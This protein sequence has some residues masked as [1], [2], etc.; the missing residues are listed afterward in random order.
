M[1]LKELAASQHFTEPPPRYSEAS[2]IKTLE[3]YGIGRPSTYASI[4]STLQYRKY[5]TLEKRRFYPTPTGRIVSKFLTKHFSDY[6]DY[7]FTAKLENVLDEISR[8][9]KTWIPA[10]KE[11][12]QPFKRLVDEKRD[13]VTKAEASSERVLG[14]DPE[15]GKPVSARYGRYGPYIQIGTKDDEEKPR[16]A[17]LRS[18]QKMETISFEEAME[19]FKLPRDLGQTLDGEPVS[20]GIG[21]YGPFIK[22]GKKYVSLKEDDPHEIDLERALIVIAEKKQTD[23]G[24]VIADF[25]KHK[26][27]VLNGRY[28]PYVTD[29]SKNVKIPKEQEPSTLTAEQCLELIAK[30]PEKRKRAPAKKKSKSK[31]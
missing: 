18:G 6:V 29:G 12:W 22:Y 16:F 3:E 8:G 1:P 30:A 25:P 27:R 11:F 17:S 5:A 23:A 20:A 28:G 26:I 7:D 10:L 21:R 2:L 24:N 19:L 14:T 4:I 13:T 15:T 31:K 9:E